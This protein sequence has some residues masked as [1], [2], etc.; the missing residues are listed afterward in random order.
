MIKAGKN[1]KENYH[2]NLVFMMKIVNKMECD[3]FSLKNRFLSSFFLH[4]QYSYLTGIFARNLKPLN[5][6]RFLIFEALKI[7][8][9]AGTLG[10][11]FVHY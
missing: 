5:T 9:R 6:Q 11:F 10:A 7:E 1:F 8:G 4:P 3:Q 2:Y